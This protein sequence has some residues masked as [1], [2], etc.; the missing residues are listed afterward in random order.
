MKRNERGISLII[1]IIAIMLMAVLVAVG[2]VLVLNKQDKKIETEDSAKF[3]KDMKDVTYVQLQYSGKTVE[4]DNELA[5]IL[6][7]LDSDSIGK[8]S[9]SKTEHA[10]GEQAYS[11]IF[12]NEDNVELY[13]IQ[14][15]QSSEE[16]C[17]WKQDDSSN[18]KLY[19]IDNE[20]VLEYITDEV[21]DFPDAYVYI[22]PEVVQTGE[23]LSFD[24]KIKITFNIP[25]GYKLS[26]MSE[27]SKTL[28]N[29]EVYI[30][31][32][33]SSIKFDKQDEA[34]NDYVKY[35]EE[36]DEYENV[37]LS[38]FETI[39]INNNTF[40][41][42]VI[43]YDRILSGK[44]T[45]ESISQCWTQV[46]DEVLLMIKITNYNKMEQ[47]DLEELLTMSFSNSVK[48]TPNEDIILNL[49]E[50]EKQNLNYE[51]LTEDII[52]LEKGEGIVNAKLVEDETPLKWIYIGEGYTIEEGG[53]GDCIEYIFKSNE[54]TIYRYT[55]LVPLT[56]IN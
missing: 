27:S 52:S 16:I 25:N 41:K 35:L 56:E 28:S 13:R 2:V 15:T 14:F 32:D 26:A 17:I 21:R 11:F 29:N 34:L 22:D 33:I 42:A 31:L 12:F 3:L 40:K 48:E 44:T 55:K 49:T 30:D 10:T 20:E 37:K 43:E 51:E 19:Y 46:T 54:K 18:I 1:L 36:D 53:G 23:L 8:K 24:G 38:E 9:L 45:K 5:E 6:L 39:T 7:Y 4:L 50:E 47:E